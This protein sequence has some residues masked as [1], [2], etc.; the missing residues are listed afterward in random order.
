[1][2][3]FVGYDP[4]EALGTWVFQNSVM[5]RSH[6]DLSFIPVWEK[7]RKF[8]PGGT[9]AFTFSRYEAALL[10]G[11]RG[12]P[13]LYCDAADMVCLAPIEDMLQHYQFNKAVQ[14]VKHP[15]Y[16]ATTPKYQGT[17]MQAENKSYP[18]K[19]W[20][21]VML[22]TPGHYSWR[23][24]DWKRTDP[25]YWTE[26]QWLGDSE[27]GELPDEWNRLVDEGQPVKGGKILHWTLG[28]P[29]IP[30]YHQSPGS[31]LWHEERKQ[32]LRTP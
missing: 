27:I 17:E 10:A 25:A 16:T 3:I 11:Y 9:N 21:S 13:V 28:V 1:M 12:E 18:K 6:K 23:K 7:A 5:R 22:I 24:I 4:R 14:V 31:L 32:A 20:T 19:N 30:H 26:M 8:A 2:R 15:E 29:A